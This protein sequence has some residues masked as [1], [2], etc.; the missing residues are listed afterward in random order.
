MRYHNS[1]AERLGLNFLHKS[2]SVDDIGKAV[3]AMRTLNLRGAAVSM[4]YKVEVLRHVDKIEEATQAIGASNSILNDAGVLTAHNTDWVAARKM[5]EIKR[6]QSQLT[7]LVILGDGGYA[8]AVW[9]A[10]QT[11]SI[12]TTK[13]TRHSWASIGELRNKIIFNCT[14]VEGLQVHESN[15][16]ID[17]IVGTETG[18]QLSLWQAREQFLLWTGLDPEAIKDRQ[19]EADRNADT[20]ESQLYPLRSSS[21]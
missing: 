3:E 21:R 15:A 19:A 7:K 13:L 20:H 18:S 9:Y 1:A 5:L 4:P 2:F 11:L 14:P 12:P 6:S 10:A 17:C 8:K 16:F